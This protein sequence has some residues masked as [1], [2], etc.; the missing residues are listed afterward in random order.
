VLAL[1]EVPNLYLKASNL[2][3]LSREPFPYAD[4]VPR[5]RSVYERFG[6]AR[7]VW[8]SNYPPSMERASYAESVRFFREL[9]FIPVC[10]RERIM[11]GN[12]LGLLRR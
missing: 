7:L 12:L 3:E 1:C 8:G 10:E 5:V 4:V 9:P 6:A 11:G 2:P